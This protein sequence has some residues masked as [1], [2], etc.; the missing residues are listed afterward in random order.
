MI[1]EV[2]AEI[3]A[4]EEKAAQILADARQSAREISLS[5]A[6]QSDAIRAEFSEETKKTVREIASDAQA[7]ASAEAATAAHNAEL[8]AAALV[9]NAERNVRSVGEWLA[10][11]I[12]KGKI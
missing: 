2:L 5:V 4:A 7:K 12:I 8:A 6:T 11:M 10:D 9:K 3:A 1:E